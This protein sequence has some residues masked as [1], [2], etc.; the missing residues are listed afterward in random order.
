[1][2]EHVSMTDI[3]RIAG[4][5][6]STVSHVLNKT[7]Y[8]SPE[9]TKRVMA[10]VKETDYRKN[11]LARAL[12][13]SKTNTVGI[14]LPSL[15]AG[16][17]YGKSLEAIE[18][19]L[20]AHGYNLIMQASANDPHREQKAIDYLLSWNVDGMIIVHC[21]ND[22]D[23]SLLPCPVVLIDRAPNQETVS[24]FYVDNYNITCQ[25]MEHMIEKGYRKIALISPVPVFAP[26]VHRFKSYKETLE[27]HGLPFLNDYICLGEATIE[28]GERFA[29]YLTQRTDADAVLITS[30]PMTVGAM[31][32]WNEHDIHI[33]NDIGVMTFAN[34]DWMPLSNPQLCGIIQPNRRIGEL[35]AK[36]L[37]KHLQGENEI[38]SQ[39]VPCKYLEGK[40]L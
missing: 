35:A 2:R 31:S 36:Q 40:S 32:Y 1:M 21:N 14:I 12:R 28:D 17:Y 6:T 33:P 25:V 23:Y 11:S 7:R 38:V 19:E 5:S 29:E 27:K 4:V 8:V 13:Q 15:H 3:A 22:Y 24:G 26:T 9:I 16:T 20:S 39:F 30:S 34:Y 18:K 37:L 10:A